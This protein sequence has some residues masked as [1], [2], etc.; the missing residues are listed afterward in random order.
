[1]VSTDR[2]ST[3]A[4]MGRKA[5]CPGDRQPSLRSAF[6]CANPATCVSR[7]KGPGGNRLLERAG[8]DRPGVVGQR[9]LCFRR[10]CLTWTHPRL[11]VVC[12]SRLPML[13]PRLPVAGSFSFCKLRA[14]FSVTATA[15][16]GLLPYIRPTFCDHFLDRWPWWISRENSFSLLRAAFFRALGIFQASVLRGPTAAPPLENERCNLH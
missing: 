13:S 10:T 7:R 15:N 4:S 11:Q 14:F 12:A 16:V 1:M 8:R 9:I 6:P 5:K 3:E 2:G